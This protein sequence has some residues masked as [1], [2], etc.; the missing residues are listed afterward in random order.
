MATDNL[1][2]ADR[3]TRRIMASQERSRPFDRLKRRI[4]SRLQDLAWNRFVA[5][6]E[7]IE[8]VRAR[9]IARDT[10]RKAEGKRQGVNWKRIILMS[11][12]NGMQTLFVIKKSK[13]IK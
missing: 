12:L 2:I 4:A 1:K 9:R 11:R 8:K 13:A 6:E 3:R 7:R 5:L 10:F